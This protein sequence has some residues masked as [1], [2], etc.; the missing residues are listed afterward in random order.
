MKYKGILY[1]LV[2]FLFMSVLYPANAQITAPGSSA[3]IQTEYPSFPEADNIYIFCTQEQGMLAASLQAQ[4]SLAGTKT[5]LWEKYNPV[6][7]SFEFFFSESTEEQQSEISGLEEGGYRV[8]ITQ[9]E[10][11]EVYR[12]WVFNNHITATAAIDN[13]SCESFT[14][15]GSFTS[16]SLNYYDPANNTMLEVFQDIKVEWLQD[17]AV[18]GTIL[19]LTVF[20]PPAADTEYTLRVFD[21]FGCEATG[22]VIYESIVPK[23]EFTADPME[24]EAPLTVNFTNLSQNA[25]PGS[26]QWFFYRDLD[27]LK[28]ESEASQQ[29]IDSIMTLAFN[30]SPV[31]T[32]ESSG[33]YKVK[34]VAIKTT[35]TQFVCAD[36]AY[37]A[38][39]IRVDTSFVV[40]PN[41]FTPNGD[42]DND[43]FVIKFWSMETMNISIFNRWGKRIHFWE[44]NNVRGFEDAF[45]EAVWDGRLG[46]RFAS[47]GVYYY[48]VEG[49]GRD[50][51]TRKAHG[52]FHLFRGNE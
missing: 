48:V 10:T 33:L 38:D 30:D 6:S 47:P 9:G 5:F 15:Q 20:D 34:L 51:K 49:R 19:E 45:T 29:P 18:I 27:D 22:S 52:F 42:G 2:Y 46:G 43:L 8:T 11:V 26:Y 4:T 14:L 21:R 41:V 32:Y 1:I 44:S 36:T 50:K 24:G 40:V 3:T 17:Q 7:G 13:V 28:R 25:D 37:I 35:G 12:S 16:P 23:A 31:Y 39:F